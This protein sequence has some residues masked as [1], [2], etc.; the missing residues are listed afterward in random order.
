MENKINVVFEISKMKKLPSDLNME[1]EWLKF[2]RNFVIDAN[3]RANIYFLLNTKD[4]MIKINFESGLLEVK[5]QILKILKK[6]FK[7]ID[8]SL[9]KFGLYSN[10]TELENKTILIFYEIGK[11][12]KPIE[13]T[14]HHSFCFCSDYVIAET[15]YYEDF[16]VYYMDFEND[17]EEAKKVKKMKK[18]LN[19]Y[20]DEKTFNKINY[21][22]ISYEFLTFLESKNL[23]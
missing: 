21:S 23:V 14:R 9:I 7:T 5:R 12:D 16:F 18:I 13:L 11:Y 8:T 17:D 22:Q 19:G 15:L 3:N 4:E 2:V 6:K 10:Q 20:V 1:T